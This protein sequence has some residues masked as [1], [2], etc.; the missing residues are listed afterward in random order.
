VK[1]YSSTKFVT[2][3]YESKKYRKKQKKIENNMIAVISTI[4]LKEFQYK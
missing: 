1:E 4:T 3:K 2:S